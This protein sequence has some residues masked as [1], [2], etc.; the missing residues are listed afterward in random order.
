M[1]LSRIFRTI[2]ISL[3]SLCIAIS[4]IFIYQQWIAFHH[5]HT[6]GKELHV[7]QNAIQAI[8][9]LTNERIFISAIIG[10]KNNDIAAIEHRMTQLQDDTDSSMIQLYT[11][12]RYLP[13]HQQLQKEYISWKK[14][15]DIVRKAAFNTMTALTP[16]NTTQNMQQTIQAYT[17]LTVF[18]EQT[19]LL[20]AEDLMHHDAHSI[21]QIQSLKSAVLMR[22]QATILGS[23]L[24]P[25]ITQ[26]RTLNTE[27]KN[28]FYQTKYRIEALHAKLN[29]HLQALPP[30]ASMQLRAKNNLETH[31]FQVAIPA[32]EQLFLTGKKSGNYAVTSREFIEDYTNN[33]ETMRKLR[34]TLLQE[35]INQNEKQTH[36]AFN[37]LMATLIIALISLCCIIYSLIVLRARLLHPLIEATTLLKLPKNKLYKRTLLPIYKKRDDASQLLISLHT[38]RMKEEFPPSS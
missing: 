11:S 10:E 36:D 26:K 4:G 23:I 2:S 6:F 22:N 27:E 18:A 24:I 17:G 15:A 33:I 16:K 3:M 9:K 38:I 5:Y 32:A 25:A 31:Y 30:S 28:H 37:Y 21:H 20:I 35:R 7:F 8:E 19:L 14:K 29:Y 1:K 34:M 13:H 12:Q